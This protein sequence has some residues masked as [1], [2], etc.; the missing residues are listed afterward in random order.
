VQIDTYYPETGRF[1]EGLAMAAAEAVFAADSAAAIAHLR[2]AGRGDGPHEH[3]VIAASM[4]DLAIS[5]RG[6]IDAGMLWLIDHLRAPTIPAP[7]RR[8]HQQAIQLANPNDGWSAL[9][10]IPGGEDIVASWTRRRD[11]L[12]TY[13]TALAAAGEIAP[14]SVLSDLLHL[15]HARMAGIAPDNER[16]C[17]RLARAAALSWVTY[18]RGAP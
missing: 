13:R 6:D 18:M 9:R 10:A 4:V 12:A 3:A 5:M 11:A 8:I 17:R 14:D 1:G 16:L 7:A 15:H 2:A